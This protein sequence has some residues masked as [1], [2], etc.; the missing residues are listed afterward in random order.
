MSLMM[1][2]FLGI[3]ALLFVAAMIVCVLASF[4]TPT[5]PVDPEEVDAQII[6]F[7][8]RVVNTPAKPTVCPEETTTIAEPSEKPDVPL[9]KTE[10]N[11]NTRNAS[12]KG[13]EQTFHEMAIRVVPGREQRY[14]HVVF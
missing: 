6:R 11:V 1:Y 12:H 3:V 10:A 14:R 13:Y 7:L 8:D 2:I 9:L 5:V 4:T